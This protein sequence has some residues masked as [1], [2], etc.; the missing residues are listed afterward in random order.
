MVR[1][2]EHQ[3]VPPGKAGSPAKATKSSIATAGNNTSSPAATGPG[4]THL[5]KTASRSPAAKADGGTAEPQPPTPARRAMDGPELA[6]PTEAEIES[7]I[8]ELLIKSEDFAPPQE[9]TMV[10]GQGP[11]GVQGPA[12]SSAFLHAIS[13]RLRQRAAARAVVA[14][15]FWPPTD[16]LTLSRPSPLATGTRTAFSTGPCHPLPYLRRP[17]L[18][19]C[20]ESRQVRVRS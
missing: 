12:H 1:G 3:K 14:L 17:G 18:K 6:E 5:V 7:Q 16:F 15:L 4:R 2:S 8:K 9:L 10:L 11:V 13:H 19:R 20:A